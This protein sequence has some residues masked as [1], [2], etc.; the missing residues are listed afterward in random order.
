M[1]TSVTR[2]APRPAAIAVALAVGLL[3]LEYVL[4]TP[5]EDALRQFLVVLAI[6]AVGMGIVFGVVVPRAVARGGSPGLALTLSLLGL[7]FAGVFWSGLPPVLAMGG[8]AVARS[9]RDQ[10]G[11]ARVAVGA[12]CV[13]LLADLAAVIADGVI[14][15]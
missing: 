11:L 2:L 7:L 9:G 6:I 13:A 10:G 15:G 4:A 5:S 1:D 3:V 8:I 12:G 14:N